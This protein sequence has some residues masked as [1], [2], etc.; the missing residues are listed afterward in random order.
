MYKRQEEGFDLF[1]GEK[2]LVKIL[3][4]NG[5]YQISIPEGA[6]KFLDVYKRQLL[7]LLIH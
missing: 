3:T 1:I 4:G 6:D 7:H 2:R 5:D